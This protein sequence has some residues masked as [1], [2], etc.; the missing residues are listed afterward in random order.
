ML[1]YASLDPVQTFLKLAPAHP[2]KEISTDHEQVIPFNGDELSPASRGEHEIFC[3][4]PCTCYYAISQSGP[5]HVTSRYP[6][7]LRYHHQSNPQF[8]HALMK[9]FLSMTCVVKVG[10]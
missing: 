5:L 4:S 3:E 7:W 1:S 9:E 8:R 2:R 10:L 6:I